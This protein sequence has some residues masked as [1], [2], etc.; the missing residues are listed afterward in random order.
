MPG[1]DR[2]HFPDSKIKRKSLASNFE[3]KLLLVLVE[4]QLEEPFPSIATRHSGVH[5]QPWGD[6]STQDQV[7]EAANPYPC[8]IDINILTAGQIRRGNHHLR[9]RIFVKHPHDALD[10]IVAPRAVD[11]RSNN[12][13]PPRSLD[14]GAQRI[15]AATIVGVAD[16]PQ[17][18]IFRFEG[19]S[20]SKRI[21]QRTVVD[22]D[23]LPWSVKRREIREHPAHRCFDDGGLVVE[24][25]D[26][27]NHVRLT[28]MTRL[29]NA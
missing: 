19:M 4:W 11:F 12:N 26:D 9:I 8:R 20:E 6:R 27:G 29:A 16:D 21:V 18:R 23:Q 22:D 5:R 3:M 25:A 7:T 15:T 2:G 17:M 13:A 14:A 10:D 1:Q 28:R 24:R